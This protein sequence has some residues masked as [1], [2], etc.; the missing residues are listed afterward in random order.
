MSDRR[1]VFAEQG[2]SHITSQQ[3]LFTFTQCWLTLGNRLQRWSNIN[4]ALVKRLVFAEQ[5]KY[6]H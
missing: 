5:G 6:I 1:L 4:R 2:E 3:T